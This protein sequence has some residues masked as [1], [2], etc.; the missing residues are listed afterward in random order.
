MVK[1]INGCLENKCMV[2]SKSLANLRNAWISQKSFGSVKQLNFKI[3]ICARLSLHHQS[4]VLKPLKRTIGFFIGK[5]LF[6]WDAAGKILW[7]SF[8][9]NEGT[10]LCTRCLCL[11]LSSCFAFPSQ[12]TLTFSPV[13]CYQLVFDTFFTAITINCP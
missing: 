1:N 8:V 10:L 12:K 2:L 13:L 6:A 9:K 7:K 3:F 11:Q 4:H 5:L